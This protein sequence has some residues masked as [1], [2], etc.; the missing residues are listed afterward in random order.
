MKKLMLTA[1][2]I[3]TS[4]NVNAMSD[5]VKRAEILLLNQEIGENLIEA[6]AYRNEI[7]AEM[8]ELRAD[9]V[10][11]E[12]EYINLENKCIE[13]LTPITKKGAALQRKLS[14]LLLNK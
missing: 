13:H 5:D 3:S 12:A 4:L 11:D 1:L 14:A 10:T 8:A 9:H 2:L 7:K 6:Q